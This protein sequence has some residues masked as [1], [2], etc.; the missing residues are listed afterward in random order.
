MPSLISIPAYLLKNTLHRWLE[1]FASPA[2]K[3][4][5]P[6]LFSLLGLLVL[7]I[8]QQVESRLN[9]QLNRKEVRS[10]R[11]YENVRSQQAKLRV[12]SGL[13]EAHLWQE[14]CESYEAFQQAPVL[15]SMPGYERIPVL[16]Y[17]DP[18]SFFPVHETPPGEPRAALLL[19]SFGKPGSLRTIEI[20]EHEFQVTVAELPEALGA[21]LQAPS[22]AVFPFE[23]IRPLLNG[24]FAQI[25]ILTPKPEIPTERLEA[26]IRA[27]ADAEG[28]NLRI[29][30]MQE[31]IDGLKLLLSQQKQ[32]RFAIGVF[33]TIILSLILGSLSLLEFRQEGYLIALLRSFGIRPLMLL[34]HYILETFFLTFCGVL[35]AILAYL[36]LGPTIVAK[37]SE[38][39][40]FESAAFLG[41]PSAADYQAL[42]LAAGL[43][44]LI[45]AVPIAFGLRKQ[46]GLLLP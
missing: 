11:T 3:G 23:Y 17:N 34:G 14:H 41:Q 22:I 29:D 45:S 12:A 30:T 15:A 6:F 19:T 13:S 43:G 7:G 42:F 4:L 21:Q 32:A 44:V 16:T 10:I 5:V 9:E 28:R 39:L 18:P 2:T 26:L 25:Q 35:L 40:D 8:L 1:N 36:K 20:L 46:P 31:I 33:I 37:L 38:S 27:H 24:G